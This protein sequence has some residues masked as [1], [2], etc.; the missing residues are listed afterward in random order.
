MTRRAAGLVG[1]YRLPR[2]TGLPSRSSD[3]FPAAVSIYRSVVEKAEINVVF[4]AV[5]TS[6]LIV[7]LLAALL[8][9]AVTTLLWMNHQA[10]MG[11]T[12]VLVH[13]PHPAVCSIQLDTWPIPV[14]P[15]R[16]PARAPP[17]LVSPYHSNPLSWDEMRTFVRDG[18]VADSAENLR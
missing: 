17:T 15:R 7:V 2:T 12:P 8:L 4:L 5:S 6:Q 10:L 1:R 18:Y 9:L 16:L 14:L 11:R 13:R 3:V